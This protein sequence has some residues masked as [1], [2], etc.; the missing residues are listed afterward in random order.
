MCH[1]VKFHKNRLNRGR[2]IVIFIFFKT[3][4]TAILDIQNFDFSTVRTVE[5]V[6]LHH[7]TKFRRNRLNCGRSIW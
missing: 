4:A 1:R 6:E 2:N 7:C 5:R 3:A